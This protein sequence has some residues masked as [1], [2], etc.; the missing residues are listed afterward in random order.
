MVGD[1]ERCSSERLNEHHTGNPRNLELHHVTQ[2]PAPFRVEKFLHQHFGAKRVR[3][4]WFALTD[5]ELLKAVRI[6]EGMI[7]RR[8]R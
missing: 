4:E 7:S 6:S 2:T 8:F 3:S 5:K 1:T